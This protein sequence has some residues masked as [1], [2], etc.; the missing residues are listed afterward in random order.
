MSRYTISREARQDLKE[1]YRYLAESNPSA[2]GRV[3]DLFFERFR[4]LSSHP[5]LGE[6]REDLGR[7]LRIFPAGRY[8]VLYRPTKSGVAI[9]KIVHSARDLAALVARRERD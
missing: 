8:V 6:S 1:I 5:L 4:L 7:D 9:A 2:V 3:D